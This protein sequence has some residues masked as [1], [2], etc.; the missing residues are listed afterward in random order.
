MISANS[1]IVSFLVHIVYDS[2]WDFHRKCSWSSDASIAIAAA[3]SLGLWN[4]FQSLSSLKAII[5]CCNDSKDIPVM[6]IKISTYSWYLLVI[7]YDYMSPVKEQLAGLT[8][9]MFQTKCLSLFLSW[10]I[11]SYVIE[12]Y[13]IVIISVDWEKLFAFF[14]SDGIFLYWWT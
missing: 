3:R 2:S 9:E 14:D 11:D 10:S 4:C 1:S 13:E 5:R 6:K 7:L 8:K 12:D